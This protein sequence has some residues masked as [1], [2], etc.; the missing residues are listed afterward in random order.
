MKCCFTSGRSSRASLKRKIYEPREAYLDIYSVNS[1]LMVILPFLRPSLK[2]PFSNY[3]K[4]TP[5][6]CG[7][8]VRSTHLYVVQMLTGGEL[9][10]KNKKNHEKNTWPIG[11]VTKNGNFNI[12]KRTEHIH[13]II[14]FMRQSTEKL[15]LLL[16]LRGV[17]VRTVFIMYLQIKGDYVCSRKLGPR[18]NSQGNEVAPYLFEGSLYFF[19]S[20]IFLVLGDMDIYYS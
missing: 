13:F 16:I 12:F 15:Y 18:I 11:S 4:A 19:S 1:A 2:I 20:D 5:F 7:R 8:R 6:L 3:H 10:F 9:L 17:T 14:H